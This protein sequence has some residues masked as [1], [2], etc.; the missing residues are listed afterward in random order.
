MNPLR[1]TAIKAA[2]RTEL[3]PDPVEIR[4]LIEAVATSTGE[5][6][7]LVR[8]ILNSMRAGPAGEVS[9]TVAGGETL[10]VRGNNLHER[11]ALAAASN[12]RTLVTLL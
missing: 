7:G 3:D 9:F 2:L 4:A 12:R 10:S 5:A 8:S 11:A 1:L 6:A